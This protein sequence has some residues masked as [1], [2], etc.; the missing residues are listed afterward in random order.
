MS[1]YQDSELKN[2]LAEAQRNLESQEQE[3]DNLLE[4]HRNE[5]LAFTN[6]HD[7]ELKSLLDKHQSDF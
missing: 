3:K 5:K 6:D 7:F 1:K 2:Q 4:T